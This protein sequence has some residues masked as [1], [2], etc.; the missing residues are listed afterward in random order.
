MSNTYASI[1]KSQLNHGINNKVSFQKMRI[2]L[3][4]FCLNFSGERQT[5]PKLA[6]LRDFAKGR[7]HKESQKRS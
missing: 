3:F 6:I 2:P 1:I 7:V 4:M 5:N